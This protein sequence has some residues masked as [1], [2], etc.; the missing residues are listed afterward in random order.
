MSWAYGQQ[1]WG[2]LNSFI[3]N[4]YGVSAL[5]GNMISESQLLPFIKQGNV[6]SPWTPSF[7]YTADVNDGTISESTFVNDSIGYGLCQWTFYSR[8]QGL[9]NKC[10]KPTYHGIDN[11]EYQLYFIEEELTGDYS[12]T[13]SVLQNAT[14]STLWDAVGNVLH[15]YEGPAD[16]GYAEQ[17]ERYNNAI[18]VYNTYSGTTPIPPDPPIPPTPP[19]EHG[20]AN[21]YFYMGKKFK[22]K[23]GLIL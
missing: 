13:L 16:Q 23:K 20:K 14:E 8:K 6:H 17:L 18:D 3:N 21:L 5:M 19:S 22:Q 11:L 12:S 9:Y 7:E 4:E 15:N 10:M 2:Y 1:I